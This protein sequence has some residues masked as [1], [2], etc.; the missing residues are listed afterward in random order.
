MNHCHKYLFIFCVRG[1]AH[2]L[3]T[4]EIALDTRLNVIVF[5]SLLASNT[6]YHVACRKCKKNKFSIFRT[7]SVITSF[8]VAVITEISRFRNES[9]YQGRV[10]I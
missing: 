4:N 2:V 6:I 10:F 1:S 9:I 7:I 8:L 3:I 5:L